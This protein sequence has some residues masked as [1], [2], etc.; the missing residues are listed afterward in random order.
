[1]F[2]RAKGFIVV[3]VFA[4]AAVSG[5]WLLERGLG[6]EKTVANGPRLFQQVA[7]QIKQT[8]VD[9]VSDSALY[10]KALVGMLQEL[11]DP[12]T[13]YLAPDRLRRLTENTTGT[14]AGIGVQVDMRDR[15]PT[16]LGTISGTPAER[17]G[18]LVGDRI[19]QVDGKSARG[20]TADEARNAIRGEP[21][22]ILHL[23]IE[24]PGTSA[25]LSVDVPRGEIHRAAVGR[26]ALV[27][28]G[29]GYV[30]LNVFSDSTALELTRTVDSL[31]AAGMKSLVLDLRGNPGGLLTQGVSV[32]DLFLDPKQE[33]VSMHG[34]L[35]ETNT[36][37][38]DRQPQLCPNLPLVLLVDEGSASASEIVAGALQDHDRAVLL[39]RTT[40]GK[41]SAQSLFPTTAGGA[42]KLTIA[43]WFTPAGRSIDRHQ[44]QSD[45]ADVDGG[46]TDAD[47]SGQ[48][49]QRYRTDAGR[50]VY[51]G[52]GI[53]PDVVAGDTALSASEQALQSALGTRVPEF[54][55]AMTAY[56]L[57]LKTAGSVQSP[58]FEVTPQMLDAL[59]RSLQA[60]NLQL[61]RR[62]YD[63]ASS[64]VGRLLAREIARYVFGTQAE[65][66]RAIRQDDV[67][68]RA[69][70][71][72][73]GV[74]TPTELL[75]RVS[76]K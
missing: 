58:D 15:W 69:V 64:I 74:S 25:P 39:G 2:M 8:Y 75:R 47:S 46:T 44:S 50:I 31:V 30:D 38:R 49:R 26:R 67:V 1:M 43:R 57:Q 37:F 51:G 9:S 16:V 53:A 76:S 11:H 54:R 24:R 42:V 33:I 19:V 13:Q 41:G 28:D 5:G 17:A 60:R 59:W 56:A 35:P 45:Q 14:Y 4:T 21:G 7:E 27:S 34:R 48:K 63:G 6:H 3:T 55:D 20:W 72:A 40:F 10:E 62:V 32:A 22:S 29:V 66:L 18:L 61:D 36:E 52:G 71:L 73:A 23:M 12:H 70:Q 65:A 68:Q